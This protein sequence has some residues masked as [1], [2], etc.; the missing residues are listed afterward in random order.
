MSMA[1]TPSQR[2]Q[3]S[4]R[5]SQSKSFA[6]GLRDNQRMEKMNLAVDQLKLK[7]QP[8][9]SKNAE[10]LETQKN[11]HAELIKQK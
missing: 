2:G 5:S 7:Y 6:V 11:K 8:E 4:V 3:L 1:M 10:I 9:I